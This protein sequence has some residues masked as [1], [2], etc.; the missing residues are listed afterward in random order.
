MELRNV[1]GIV[2]TALVLLIL[3]AA[4]AGA[5]QGVGTGGAM[6]SNC[7]D[8]QKVELSDALSHAQAIAASAHEYLEAVGEDQRSFDEAYMTW[9]G[10]Y[11]A[12]RYSKVSTSFSKIHT[13]LAGQSVAFECGCGPDA[14]G[15]ELVPGTSDSNKI[16]V[17]DDFW[18]APLSGFNSRG[19]ALVGAVSQLGGTAGAED[20][21]SNSMLSMKLAT[22][23]PVKAIQNAESYR[24]FAEQ[25]KEAGGEKLLLAV[26]LGLL[27][28]LGV[29]IGRARGGHPHSR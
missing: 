2:W 29:R 14:A 13:A 19:G 24:F 28:L 15:R 9:F 7:S 27:L 3:I 23:D 11:N 26:P 20:L 25:E 12:W 17:C 10:S 16:G 8:E 21:A 6:F 18:S 4:P 5:Q 1:K 22:E